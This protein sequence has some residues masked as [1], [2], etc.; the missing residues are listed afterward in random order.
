[1]GTEGRR[2]RKSGTQIG[3]AAERRIFAAHAADEAE[4]YAAMS[5]Q[6]KCRVK[7]LAC[8]PTV[9][10]RGRDS[11]PALVL[12]SEQLVLAAQPE[13]RALLPSH[14]TPISVSWSML[15]LQPS[16]SKSDDDLHAISKACQTLT[17]KTSA[18]QSL[19]LC[20]RTFTRKLRL[21]AFATLALKRA[22]FLEIAQSVFEQLIAKQTL[23]KPARAM[24]W[25]TKYKYDE[26]SIRM[27]SGSTTH[28]KSTQPGETSVMKLLQVT[29]VWQALF[30]LGAQYI[31][32]VMAVPSLLRPIAA[33]DIDS[34][35]HVIKPQIS[36]PL[37]VR[38]TFET[39]HRLPICDDHPTNGGVDDA[40]WRASPDEVPQKFKCMAHKED[41]VG[42]FV[43][44]PF[45]NDTLGLT[46]ITLSYC[47][48]GCWRRFKDR[49]KAHVRAVLRYWPY[50]DHGAGEAA[51]R[52]REAVFARFAS[53]TTD[54]RTGNQAAIRLQQ[55]HA[56]RRLLNG[57]YKIKGVVEHWCKGPLFCCK[58]AEDTLRQ[59]DEYIID[60]LPLPKLVKTSSWDMMEDSADFHGFWLLCHDI[61]TPVYHDSF[62]D[63]KVA[64]PAVAA[65]TALTNVDDEAEE[66]PEQVQEYCDLGLVAPEKDAEAFV[67]QNTF[68]SNAKRWLA[69]SPA[70]RLWMMRA[71]MQVQQRA[72]QRL[73]KYSGRS[74]DKLEYKW[75]LR[76]EPPAFRVVLA[77][78]GKFTYEPIFEFGRL[79][80]DRSM[81][82]HH[83]REF[84]THDFLISVY[85]SS[86]AGAGATYQLMVV[87]MRGFPRG[88]QQWNQ[89]LR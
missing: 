1:M 72:Q 61:L 66:P 21:L 89:A 41:K 31:R 58:D 37:W 63:T 20:T 48:G 5:K 56:R 78:E 3:T 42:D 65:H 60:P 62:S 10:G 15:A 34:L 88:E 35:V 12:V 27:H 32:I 73:R 30:A 9:A 39:K 44:R 19:G 51:G 26:V 6:Q 77:H 81:W 75:R 83:P 85:K 70:G 28:A 25:W 33:N 2:G 24:D 71:A 36:T 59:I 46:N 7:R 16:R 14:A 23:D 11:K 79:I 67:R 13:D 54:R 80:R 49:F 68:R 38:D 57:R 74:W 84:C 29:V 50:G 8:L 64:S 52:H 47:F 76:G 18:S 45:P 86:A 69:S 55:L 40:L 87:P 43:L 22:K 53:G 4:A 82:E 17:T